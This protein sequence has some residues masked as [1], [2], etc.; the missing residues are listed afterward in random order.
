MP[1]LEAEPDAEPEVER[2][3]GGTRGGTRGLSEAEPSREQLIVGLRR[4]R[5]TIQDWVE[6][7]AAAVPYAFA[8]VTMCVWKDTQDAKQANQYAHYLQNAGGHTE[9]M[10]CAGSKHSMGLLRHPSS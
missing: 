6:W 1:E 9:V 4:K 10:K 5:V 7:Y 3:R 8:I 2:T